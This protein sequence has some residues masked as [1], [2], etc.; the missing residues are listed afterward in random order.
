M[1]LEYNLRESGALGL[2]INQYSWQA[3]EMI[4]D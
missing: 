1:L 2:Q 3:V 4:T